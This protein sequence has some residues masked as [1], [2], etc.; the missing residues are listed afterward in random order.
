MVHILLLE[1]V[2]YFILSVLNIVKKNVL[3]RAKTSKNYVLFLPQVIRVYASTLY[4]RWLD[5]TK[6]QLLRFDYI[7][8][9]TNDNLCTNTRLVWNRFNIIFMLN[10]QRRVR[11]KTGKFRKIAFKQDGLLS[12]NNPFVG[13]LVR[14]ALSQH[15]S[16]FAFSKS[17][18]IIHNVHAHLK[19][20]M[21]FP[22]ICSK[23]AYLGS[24]EV[25]RGNFLNNQIQIHI[26]TDALMWIHKCWSTD[27]DL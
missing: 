8:L 11:L 12:T 16:L 22:S 23:F 14:N 21:T 10:P 19:I 27:V 9:N 24:S 5:V 1:N 4:L 26:S 7:L 13:K 6:A 17:N 15:P 18:I 20:T 3:L 2:K 25:E